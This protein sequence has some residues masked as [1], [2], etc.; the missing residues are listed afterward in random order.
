MKV[1]L[2]AMFCLL[3]AQGFATGQLICISEDGSGL[4]ADAGGEKGSRPFN[5]RYNIREEAP[6]EGKVLAFYSEVDES[7]IEQVV[8]LSVVDAETG[9]LAMVISRN[10]LFD[11]TGLYQAEC[12]FTY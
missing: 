1:L 12:Y 2:L 10:S 5:V 8:S 7:S 6:R 11:I 3:S 9:E 4:I